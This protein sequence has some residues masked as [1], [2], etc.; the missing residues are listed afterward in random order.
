[1]TQP[2]SGVRVIAVSQFGAGPYGMTQLAD[3]G[4]DVIKVEDPRTRGDSA[5]SV[6]PGAIESDSLYYQSLNRNTRSIA[7]NLRHVEGQAILHDLVRVSDAIFN[8]LRGD[9]PDKLGLTYNYLGKID[10]RI[11]CV[12][13]SGFGRTGPRRAEPGYDYLIQAYAGFM[14]LTGE[15][16]GPPARAGVSFVDFSG[17]L[18]A[19]LAIV[20]GVLQARSTG[21]GC[22]VDVG[23]LDTA[24]S[25]LN[26]LAAWTLNSDFRPERLP[27]SSHPTLYPSQVFK[28][29]DGHLVIMCAKE[30]FW[31]A[32]VERLEIP[33]LDHDPRFRTFPNR[34]ANREALIPLLK[35]GFR[36]HTTDWW[37][38]RLRGYV[39][40]APVHTVESA[41]EDEQVLARDLIV[42][43]EH[44]DFGP[45]RQTAS[46]VRF[47]GERPAHR[48]AS[49]M[50]ADTV[51]VLHDLLGY[52]AHRI[53]HLRDLGAIDTGDLSA[54]VQ[55]DTSRNPNATENN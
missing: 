41:L 3:L 14:S 28:T 22:D 49:S 10:P 20:S 38:E 11:V 24:V 40:C 52:D 47:P 1:M 29:S 12:S 21:K 42:D 2:L 13:L 6:H 36:R 51:T 7:L 4:A 27:D 17:G 53:A 43:V 39:P 45:M 31:T 46:A 18:A 33:G 34:Y 5:R 23:L 37:L 15:P 19:A 48:S 55:S 32:L 26:Y 30:K 8:N 50:G 9:Q 44:P 54:T 16:D 35:D 25:M